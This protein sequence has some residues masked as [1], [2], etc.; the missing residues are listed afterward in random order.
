MKEVA[1]MAAVSCTEDDEYIIQRVFA[2]Y[3]SRCMK[4]TSTD[5]TTVCNYMVPEKK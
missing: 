1:I 3:I 2:H 4:L 5:I